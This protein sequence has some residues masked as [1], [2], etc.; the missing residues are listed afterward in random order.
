MLYCPN[1]TCQTLNLEGTRICQQ[2][3]SPLPYRYLWAAG[4][5]SPAPEAGRL[6]GD[7]YLSKGNGIFL[8]T[9]PGYPPIASIEE[10]P[11]FLLAYL[12]LAALRL[13]IPLAYDLIPQDPTSGN[14][15]LLLLEEAAL[16]QPERSVSSS[17]GNPSTVA[18][19]PAITPLWEKVS[20]R[21]Q[22]SWLWQIANLWEP[23][24][25]EGVGSTL[26]TPE[27]LRVEGC[28]LRIL[29]L[30]SDHPDQPATL[31]H[32]GQLWQTWQRSA[33]P[34]IAAFLNTLSAGLLEGRINSSIALIEELDQQIAI[35]NRGKP[36]HI[37]IATQTDQG[38]TR[39][40]NEDACYPASGTLQSEILQSGQPSSPLAIVCDGIGGHQG[41]DVASNLAIA[42]VY[43]KLQN[44]PVVTL[45]PE[46]IAYAIDESVAIANDR[47]SQ[48]N[49]D[50]QRQDRQRMGTTLVMGLIKHQELYVG[51]VGDS[52][53]YWITPWGCH[54]ITLD[55]DVASRQMRLGYNFY[56]QALQHPNAGS[57]VQALGMSGSSLL[58]PTVQRLLIDEDSVL[59]FCSDGL[60]D[61]DRVEEYWDTNLLPVLRGQAD[62]VGVSQRLVELANTLNGHDNVTVAV[63]HYQVP[64]A[65]ADRELITNYMSSTLGDVPIPVA[66]EPQAVLSA[67]SPTT[68]PT[69]TQVVA[70]TATVVEP[71]PRRP[72][73]LFLS[74]VF[75]TVLVGVLAYLLLPILRGAGFL[76]SDPSPTSTPQP[77]P[78][79]TAPSPLA[80]SAVIQVGRVN[81]S[82]PA[83]L[84]LFPQPQLGDAAGKSITPGT[85]L[86]VIEKP[87]IEGTPWL[88]VQ[89]C[90]LGSESTAAP[91]PTEVASLTLVPQLGEEG[92]VQEAELLPRAM[93]VATEAI[94]GSPCGPT[95]TPLSPQTP[96]PTPP[97]L[98]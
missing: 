45:S 65:S 63:V 21:R 30:R 1:P 75:A 68:T 39:S 55:D 76:A 79:S 64:D 46:A 25:R 67:P 3:H 8:D 56:R 66:K 40:R 72:V 69:A 86:Q 35:A 92:W 61:G 51:H 28:L 87:S 37:H 95:A 38:P 32:L 80:P 83:P 26:L 23:M 59:L 82:N 9:L 27:L 60:S 98:G 49:D 6:L 12:R 29:E 18:V 41:G 14:A 34:D 20:G 90:S 85:V 31:A 84:G 36:R 10:L 33:Q 17:K 74:L 53:A 97:P 54:Q 16:W 24:V 91:P 48:R 70:P 44:L 88:R 42:A 77:S 94:A 19:L 50:E 62:L 57:L 47:I 89:V 4:L 11:D 71:A 7:R 73:P 15:N 22:L 52:R 2:C 96:T 81:T 13:H 93:P 78:S 58:H 43:Q 5:T